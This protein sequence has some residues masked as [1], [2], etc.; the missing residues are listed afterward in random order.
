MLHWSLHMSDSVCCVLLLQQ[1]AS[2][3]SMQRVQQRVANSQMCLIP[4]TMLQQ[5]SG[6]HCMSSPANIGVDDF[7]GSFNMSLLRGMSGNMQT[8]QQLAQNKV[9]P[10]QQQQQ[11]MPLSMSQPLPQMSQQQML[12]AANSGLQVLPQQQQQQVANPV[13]TTG[14]GIKSIAVPIEAA[15]VGNLAHH[16]VFFSNHSGAQVTITSLPGA[17][18][19]I[20][21]TGRADQ[22]AMAQSLLA[23]ARGQQ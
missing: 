12:L 16:L 14:N 17:A 7:E 6:Q 23:A 21:I 8:S 9:W 4:R 3:L 11:L 13:D 19:A 10:Q 5:G 20:M 1:L 2:N 18:L 15:E 22:V